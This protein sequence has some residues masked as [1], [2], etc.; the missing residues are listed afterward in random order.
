MKEILLFT[1][2]RTVDDTILQ[3]GKLGV[4][5]IK[6]INQLGNGTL[7]R[8][9]E[10]VERTESAIAVLNDYVKKKNDTA[11]RKKYSAND[12]KQLVERVLQTEDIRQKGQETLEDLRQQRTWYE[13]W[14]T[15]VRVRDIAFLEKKGIFL[16]LY[17]LDKSV[18]ASLGQKHTLIKLPERNGKVPTVLI[19][20]NE[21]EKLNLKEESLPKLS[22]EDIKQQIDRKERQLAEVEHFLEDQAEN[23]AWLD[24]YYLLLK[25][26]LG[27]QQ[28]FEG[29][30]DIEGKLKYLK[31]YIPC[32][33]VDDFVA[34]AES[35]HWGYHIADPEKPEDVPVY[36]KNPKWIGI[37][38]PVM[39]FIDI[40]PGYKEVDVS[41]Y[42]LVAFAL[43]FAML[44]GDAG[45]GLIFLL[46]T[47]LLRKK[48]TGQ[49]QILI[50]VLSG[51]TII[52]GVLSGTYFGS[53]QLAALPF[54]NDLIIPEIAS[55][56]VDNISF[57]MHLS[58][59]IGAVHLTIA[60]GIRVFQFI[61]SI[62]AL[63]EVGWIG[64]VWGLFL[65]T[66]QLVLGK[67]MPD[68][69][70]W[71]FVGGAILVALFSVE[72]KN[73]FKSMG[74]S[75]ANLPLSLISGFSD[76]VSYVRLFAVGMATAAVA[77][78][79][80]NMILPEGTAGMGIINLIM[81]AIALLLGHG[82]NIALALM[83]VMVHGIR[84]NMLEFAGHLGVQFSGE[85][86]KPFKLISPENGQK[87]STG[88]SVSTG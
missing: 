22:F 55:F 18:A 54:L 3:L 88:T 28:A 13:T 52:W 70:I 9:M 10:A 37:I 24:D 64:L 62:K 65:I 5:D 34:V 47:F 30:G 72:S 76:I 21:S 56:G 80:N 29:M 20:R 45:Y 78:S 58:F 48:L 60:H 32:T 11:D 87:N 43:F 14:G 33:T 61:N 25:D 8:R 79:F 59:L 31:G 49:M 83:A 85:A 44:V 77:A 51:A 38:N 63:S 16:R 42:F 68:W 69:G 46:V 17:L 50:Y 82:L 67:P 23:I 86:Y 75:L 19:A 27:M 2:A 12:P 36:I 71:L 40:V 26:R 15:K 4:V 7:E 66:E 35:N 41:I 6:E 84:L 74:V 53:E 57:M 39:K 81:A 1:T 73:F